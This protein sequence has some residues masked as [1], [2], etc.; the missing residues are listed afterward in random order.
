MRITVNLATR[1]FADTGPLLRRLRIAMAA[2]VLI[3]GALVFGLHAL[4]HSA[5]MARIRAHSL[6]GALAQIKQE[7]QGYIRMMQEPTN[8][9]LLA[10][11]KQLN[12]LFDEKAFSWTLTMESL[13]TVLPGGV[14]V[15]TLEPVREKDG[16]IML[17]MRVIGPRDKGIEFLRNLEHSK[18]F[19]SPRIVGETAEGGNNPGQKLLPVSDTN[20]FSFELLADY[21]P[22]SPE[23]LKADK[24]SA[25]AP[26]AQHRP[27]RQAAAPGSRLA[28][29]MRMEY[30]R[31]ISPAPK[32]IPAH[33][34]SLGGQR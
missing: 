20:P 12:N 15:S 34:S 3:S 8:A 33:N 19:L 9:R 17:R 22:P 5:R 28:R 16:H 7:R 14:Q 25:G 23:E 1:P 24:K 21:N 13:E 10:E 26:A 30:R 18:R 29:P 27:P 31:P 2:L 11:T 32:P 6:D 4:R